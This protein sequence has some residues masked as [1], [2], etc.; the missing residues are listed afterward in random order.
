MPAASSSLV[1]QGLRVPSLDRGGPYGTRFSNVGIDDD[2]LPSMQLGAPFETAAGATELLVGTL[3]LEQIWRVVDQLRVGRADMPFSSTDRGRLFAHG[4]ANRK[5]AIAR[6][7][8]FDA[9]PLARAAMEGHARLLAPE[10]YVDASGV[11]RLAVAARLP[12]VDWLLIV[13]QPTSEAFALADRLQRWLLAAIAA[14]L[15]V[16]LLLGAWLGRSLIVPITTLVGGTEA[17]AAGRLDTR[18]SLRG[19]DEFR[20][21]GDAFNHMATR[22]TDLQEAARRQ[23]RQAM[24]GRIVSGLVH[25]LSHPVQNLANHT[26]LLLRRPDDVEFRAAFARTVERETSSMRRLL[27]DLRQAGSPVALER[28]GVDLVRNARDAADNSRAAAEAAG[29]TLEFV[30][31]ERPLHVEADAFALGRV[32][33]NLLQNAI[34]FTPAAR[35]RVGVELDG[36]RAAVA[37][38]GHR[39][40]HRA[41]APAATVRGV[42]HDEPPRPRTGPRDLQA[43]RRATRWRDRAVQHRRV[44]HRRGSAAAA[45]GGPRGRPGAGTELMRRALSAP[46]SD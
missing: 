17:V 22:L 27:D 4:D 43:D 46:P 45:R 6:G 39:A 26:R 32:W 33:R 21:L 14:A 28:F 34:D 40:R 5:S 38:A 12:A 18:V 3:N 8:A 29:L 13:E 16:M 24:F 31:P 2:L 36:P 30:A 42:R 23:E 1:T 9:H 20:R 37:R 19:D 11:R 15:G 35:R 44:G 10:E 7:E 41:G 25:D